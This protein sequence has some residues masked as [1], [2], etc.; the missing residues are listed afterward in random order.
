M[1]GRACLDQF[2]PLLKKRISEYV[3]YDET[4][5]LGRSRPLYVP[6]RRSQSVLSSVVEGSRTNL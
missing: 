3:G 1:Y 4:A 5:P 2:R 6:L